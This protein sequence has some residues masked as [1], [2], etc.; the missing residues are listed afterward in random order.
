MPPMAVWKNEPSVRIG[1]KNSLDRNT[2]E[3]AAA[4]VATPHE[5]CHST[6]II[7]TAAPPNAKRSMTVIEFNC[8]VSRRIVA[9]RKLSAA[10][11]IS[12]CLRASAE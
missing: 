3:K 5:N 1:M 9:L 8:I 7:P 4:N 10:P 2:M 6:A 11:F 12:S